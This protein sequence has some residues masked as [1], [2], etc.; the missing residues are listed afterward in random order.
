MSIFTCMDIAEKL[1][2]MMGVKVDIATK[3]K[4]KRPRF[5]ARIE[6]EVVYV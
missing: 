1:E 5:K 3:S 4:F 2:E 6:K